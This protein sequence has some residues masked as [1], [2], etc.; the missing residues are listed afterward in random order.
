MKDYTKSNRLDNKITGLICDNWN[1]ICIF[2]LLVLSVYLRMLPGDALSGDATA[3][4]IPWYEEIKSTGGFWGLD[5]EVGD[6]NMFYQFILAILTYIPL[7]PIYAIKLSSCVF[8]YLLAGAVSAIVFELTNK[9]KVNA[10]ISLFIVLFSPLVWINSAWWAQCDAMYVSLC[11]W[12]IYFY[13]KEKYLACFVIYGFS[14]AFKLQGIFILPLFLF[15]YV[16]HKRYTILNYL[17]I[18]IMMMISAIPCVIAGRGKKSIIRV[19]TFYIFEAGIWKKMY[20]N[21]PSFW[22]LLRGENSE[23]FFEILKSPAIAFTVIIL[24]VFMTYWFNKKIE[25]NAKNIVFMAFLLSYT[26]VLF[27]P[28]MH[29][30]YGFLFEILGIAIAFINKKTI[31]PLIA[32][33]A[34]I[35]ALYGNYL[36][37]GVSATNLY[38]L[39]WVNLLIYL[40]YVYILNKDMVNKK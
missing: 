33:N 12:A 39:A 37:L 8:D 28:A 32:M 3:K 26:C 36:I 5:H 2:A 17:A 1:K 24:A 10:Y 13:I 21:Y 18:P 30:R 14:F 9:N 4:L 16:Y 27:L 6:Y 11:L 35:L 40:F 38:A 23:E 20:L 34:M 31:I 19:M 15:L 25:V 29:E 7:K 22:C